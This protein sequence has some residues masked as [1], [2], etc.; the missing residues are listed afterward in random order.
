MFSRLE[1]KLT[2]SKIEIADLFNSVVIEPCSV[3]E[4]KGF[5]QFS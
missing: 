3:F 5:K 1:I 2:D 4:H